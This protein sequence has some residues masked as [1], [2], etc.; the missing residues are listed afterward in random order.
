MV[1]A[2]VGAATVVVMN[3]SSSKTFNPTLTN[4]LTEE[5]TVYSISSL[6]HPCG[7]KLYN[8][9]VNRYFYSF[10]PCAVSFLV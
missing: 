5:L 4:R 7:V 1:V 8:A 2:V 6:L 9:R 10:Y 3:S